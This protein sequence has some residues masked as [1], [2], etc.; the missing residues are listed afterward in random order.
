MKETVSASLDG[1]VL[2]DYQTQI[3]TQLQYGPQ[4]LEWIQG[5]C[6]A[7]IIWLLWAVFSSF[8]EELVAAVSSQRG[9]F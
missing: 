5:M 7:E 6:V 8:D 9:S 1:V 2:T 4:A 3:G